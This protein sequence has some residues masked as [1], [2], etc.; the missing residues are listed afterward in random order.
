[1]Q[2]IRMSVPAQSI[3]PCPDFRVQII[4][5]QLHADAVSSFASTWVTL[6]SLA[7]RGIPHDQHDLPVSHTPWSPE[8]T[9]ISSVQI[10]VCT[11]S[12]PHDESMALGALI[13]CNM[14]LFVVELGIELPGLPVKSYQVRVYV[15][16]LRFCV[17]QHFLV[18]GT[19][20]EIIY[21]GF[22]G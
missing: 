18:D 20:C 2:T 4:E 3:I 6:T 22:Y 10:K 19:H 12:F 5:M 8:G 11:P 1:M 17:E 21:S 14:I 9:P 13:T 16:S 7:K 15:L